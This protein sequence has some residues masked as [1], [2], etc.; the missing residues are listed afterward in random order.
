MLTFIN[1][2]NQQ[3]L[4]QALCEKICEQLS[5]A[6]QSEGKASLLVS[7]GRTPIPL[8]QLLSQ[9]E[10]EWGNVTI[11]LVDDRWVSED[12]EASN[13]AM[14]KQHLLVNAASKAKFIPLVTDVNALEEGLAQAEKNAE[15]IPFPFD[16]VLL[17]MGEDGH[18]ASLFPCCKEVKEGL[19]LSNTH[20]YIATKPTNAP[21]QR[22]SLTLAALLKSKKVFLHLTGDAKKKVYEDAMAGSDIYQMPIRAVLQNKDVEVIW[23]P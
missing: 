16:V 19:N 18:T 3:I 6:V 11:S 17:G 1:Y 4:N 20:I 10:I 12:S 8:F 13:A 14:V 5:Q 21:H 7:G 23:A 22:I 15:Q 2:E 9:Q